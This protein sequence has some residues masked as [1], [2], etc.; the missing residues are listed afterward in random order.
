MSFQSS[1]SQYFISE[2]ISQQKSYRPKKSGMIQS[3]I[4]FPKR[5]VFGESYAY[6]FIQFLP[7]SW[8]VAS[9]STVIFLKEHLCSRLLYFPPIILFLLRRSL[10]KIKSTD[11][12]DQRAPCSRRPSQDRERFCHPR[13][14]P[15]APLH[16]LF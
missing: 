9:H 4:S 7:V 3:H 1:L 8:V 5:N 13:E 15:H 14:P 11:F 12:K 10:Q 2:W 6:R 16:P